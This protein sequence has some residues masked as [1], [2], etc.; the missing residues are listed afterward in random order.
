MRPPGGLR[1]NPL[2]APITIAACIVLALGACVP[3]S[4]SPSASPAGSFADPGATPESSTTFGQVVPA[5]GSDSRIYGPNPGAIV[6]A[7]DPGHGG[8]LDWGVPNPYDNTVARSEKTLTLAISLALRERLE[9]DGVTVV[10]TRDAD[11]ALAGDLYPNLG[12]HGEPFR[13]VNGD[14]YAGYG[15]LYP[16]GTRT[17]DELS[18]HIDLVNLARADVLISIH[19]NSLTEGGEVLEI[20]ATETFWTDETPWGVP[21]SERLATL[22]QDEVVAAMRGVAPYDRQDRGIDAVNYYVIAPPT[23]TGD[24]REP[25]RGILMP[26]VLAEVGSISLA[27]EADLLTTAAAQEA[28]AEALVGALVSWF[29]D[30]P[31]GV[32]FDLLAPGGMAGVAPSVEPGDGPMYWPLV[33][34]AGAPL[35]LHL[36]N[37]GTRPWPAGVQLVAGWVATTEPYLAR[38][39]QLAPLDV[40]VPA[41]A[42]GESVDLRIVLPDPA[43]E[44]RSV[45][46][47]TLRAGTTTLSDLGAPALQLASGT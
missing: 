29:A 5:P 10:M 46:W 6:V 8:C 26:G 13:D 3:A 30:R 47:I 28:I 33:V 32:R 36:T 18:A 23:E 12:C 43:S 22:V 40:E 41:L 44:V 45:A 15:A 39:P 27:T 4:V 14:G 34:S 37:T 20:A 25:R 24:P 2:Q 11:L 16:E 31:L 9:A 7:I 19:I 17:R 1:G 35:G 21:V 38:P 42:P